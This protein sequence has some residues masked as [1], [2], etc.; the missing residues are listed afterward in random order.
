MRIW[1]RAWTRQAR[2]SA[3]MVAASAALLLF[4]W[5]SALPLS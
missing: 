3:S 4:L 1:P 5:L 2:S